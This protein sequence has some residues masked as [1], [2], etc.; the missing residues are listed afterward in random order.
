MFMLNT[1]SHRA[2]FVYLAAN[3]LLAPLAFSLYI[4]LPGEGHK[5]ARQGAIP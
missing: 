2:A 1:V 3:V 4:R 5:Y